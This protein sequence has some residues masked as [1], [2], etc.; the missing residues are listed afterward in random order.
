MAAAPEEHMLRNTG[1]KKSLSG[2]AFAALLS[3]SGAV[4]GG[5]DAAAAMLTFSDEFDSLSL[6]NKYSPGAGGVWTPASWYAPNDAGYQVND[7]WMVNPFNPATPYPSLYM[8]YNGVLRLGARANTSCPSC[9]TAHYLTSQ[10]WAKDFAQ[11]HGYFE[12]RLA[13]PPVAGT[14]FAFWLLPKAPRWPP[15]IDIIEIATGQGWQVGAETL[16]DGWSAR[17]VRTCLT[18]QMYPGWDGAQYHTYGV[19]WTTTT[20]T[21][22][23]DRVARCSAPTP[24]GYDV[25]M[26]PG[27]S[28]QQG[29]ADWTGPIPS[30]TTLKPLRVDWIRVWDS[31]P[32]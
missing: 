16:W 29:A 20:I 14:N 24:A 18:Y 8:V 21:Y 12:A 4:S 11:R 3:L 6:Y 10:I 28:W 22:Y 26:F 23:I 17:T 7:G 31:R 9:G 25:A 15:E 19:E 13:A 2:A 1:N 30:G 5:A 32:F 27:L